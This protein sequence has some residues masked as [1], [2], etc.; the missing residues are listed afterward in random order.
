MLDKSTIIKI[1]DWTIEDLRNSNFWIDF[2][3]FV[4]QAENEKRSYNTNNEA[5]QINNSEFQK[6]QSQLNLFIWNLSS[7]KI[8]YFFLFNFEFF[9]FWISSLSE[10]EFKHFKNFI[11]S[12]KTEYFIFNLIQN[13]LFNEM[14]ILYETNQL[15]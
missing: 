11:Y 8:K 9:S 6:F 12:F 15:K 13:D 4:L 14:L 2:D 3:L 10:A 5:N 7:N 1:F